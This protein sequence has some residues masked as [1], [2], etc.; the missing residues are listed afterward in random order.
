MSCQGFQIVDTDDRH[1]QSACKYP[2]V[3]EFDGIDIKLLL[4]HRLEG[5]KPGTETG[6]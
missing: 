2:E 4:L 6:S 5:M 1:I 3:V